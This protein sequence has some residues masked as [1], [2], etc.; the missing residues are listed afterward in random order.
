[1]MIING[2]PASRDNFKKSRAQEGTE[3][4]LSAIS[5]SDIMRRRKEST[6]CENK[7][8]KDLLIP[9]LR[10]GNGHFSKRRRLQIFLYY[11]YWDQRG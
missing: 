6:K 8:P 10:K 4:I 3:K 5:Q 7:D 2:K 1:M 9:N 11:Y